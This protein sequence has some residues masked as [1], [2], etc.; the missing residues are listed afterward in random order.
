MLTFSELETFKTRL[1]GFWEPGEE[2]CGIVDLNL[3]IVEVQ[4]RAEDP[5][6]TF[7]FQLKDLENGVKA[8]WHSHPVT[9]ANLSIDDYRFF[10][11]WPEMLHFIIGVDGVRCYQV[12][13]GIVYYVE[14]EADYSPRQ[15]EG[16]LQP[17][18]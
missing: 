11:A 10:Q 1:E 3:E 2:R 14:D 15:D 5:E 8:T 9:T 4:N 12:H 17:S 6:N 18:D 7:A 13:D 16:S